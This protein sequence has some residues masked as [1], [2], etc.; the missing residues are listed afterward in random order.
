MPLRGLYTKTKS[1]IYINKDAF[2][3]ALKRSTQVIGIMLFFAF[4]MFYFLGGCTPQQEPPPSRQ[5]VIAN[6]FNQFTGEHF[7]VK[8]SILSLCDYPKSYEHLKTMCFD[9]GPDSICV[10]TSFKLYH[11][12]IVRTAEAYT[13]DDGTITKL[14]IQ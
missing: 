8:D 4:M 13:H 9:L 6:Q 11:A 5:D 12:N 10:I 14:N 1:M 3:Y 7:K 2:M